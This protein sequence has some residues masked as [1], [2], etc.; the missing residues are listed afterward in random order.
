LS[1]KAS[2]A[3]GHLDTL[4]DPSVIKDTTSVAQFLKLHERK[5]VEWA[6]M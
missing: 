4:I 5:I 1:R 3:Q 6:G 2:T